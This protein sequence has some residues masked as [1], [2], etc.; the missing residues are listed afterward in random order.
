MIAI[1]TSV[2]YVWSAALT[3]SKTSLKKLRIME[4]EALF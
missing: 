3:C 4:V 2:G 1:S